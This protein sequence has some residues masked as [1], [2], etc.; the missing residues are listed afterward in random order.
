MDN[1]R[2]G[3][4]GVGIFSPKKEINV[5]GLWRGAHCFGA[6]FIFTIQ[7]RYYKQKS[8]TSQ[9][10]KQVP[11][12]EYAELS[13]FYENI[14]KDCL[15]VAVETKLAGAHN[16][17]N[18]VHP[19]RAIYVMGAE[20]RGLIKEIVDRADRLVYVDVPLCLN[21]A[22]TGSIIMYDRAIKQ[23]TRG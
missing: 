15:L 8:D 18:F 11:F 20:D 19:E 22:T 2:R 21:V 17:F 6:S 4:F 23:Y 10:Y 16:L 12:Y 1:T 5:G 3:Y 7:G 14:P 13:Q 9:A